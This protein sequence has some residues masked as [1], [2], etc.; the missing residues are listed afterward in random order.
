MTDKLRQTKLNALTAKILHRKGIAKYEWLNVVVGVLTII[1]PIFFI[2]AQYVTK[3]E[4]AENIINN[5]G[6][7]LSILLIGVSVLAMM[8]KI[9]E[10]ITTHKV[11]IK[12]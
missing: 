5:I 8:L 6:F 3:G 4:P 10:R 9:T 12:N 7:G 2:T 11:G 1:V